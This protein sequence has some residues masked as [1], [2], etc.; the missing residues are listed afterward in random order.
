MT[1]GLPS[2]W[3]RTPVRVFDI[4]PSVN[5]VEDLDYFIIAGCAVLKPDATNG[6]AWGSEILKKITNFKGLAGYHGSAPADNDKDSSGNY[7]PNSR[8]P[9][10]R[11]AERFT[12]LMTTEQPN[13]YGTAHRLLNSWLQANKEHSSLAIVYNATHYWMVQETFIRGVYCVYGPNAWP[14]ER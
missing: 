14:I 3:D 7:I 13:D 5:W 2:C 10:V 8:G 9:A 12:V 1:G 6:F 4:A 11:I